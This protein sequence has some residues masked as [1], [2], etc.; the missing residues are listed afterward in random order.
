L[1]TFTPG[2]LN[3]AMAWYQGASSQMRIVKY[4][5]FKIHERDIEWNTHME[6]AFGLRAFCKV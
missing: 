5:I 1:T 4:C 2:I 3:Y 6:R